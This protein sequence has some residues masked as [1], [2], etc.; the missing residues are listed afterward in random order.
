MERKKVW[1]LFFVWDFEKEEAWLNEMAAEGWTLCS[2]GFCNYTFERSLPEEY[3]IRMEMRPYDPEYIRFMEETGVEYIGR[4]IQWLYFRKRTEEGPFD[5]FSDIDSKIEHLGRIGKMIASIGILNLGIGILNS[6]NP[7]HMGWINL[8]CAT[9][10]MYALGRIHGE[11]K[12]LEKERSL[13][14]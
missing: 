1:K 3:T 5:L 10:L 12:Y 11:K 6:V 8:L 13:R 2:V 4:I 9:L 14:E 7:T